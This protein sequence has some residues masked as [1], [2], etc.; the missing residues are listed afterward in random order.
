MHFDV[1]HL[2]NGD[3]LIDILV[4]Y[5]DLYMIFVFVANDVVIALSNCKY[6]QTYNYCLFVG[7]EG[8]IHTLP[9]PV[10]VFVY[11]ISA[12]FHCDDFSSLTVVNSTVYPFVVLL[13]HCSSL[14]LWLAP[15]NILYVPVPRQGDSSSVVVVG[16][17]T[18]YL[19]FINCLLLNL[20]N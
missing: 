12:L 7:C 8:C 17:Y 13:H 18:S 10:S 14:V 19:F 20:I 4:L 6:S 1:N 15:L 5:I 16:S 2:D 11:C 9:R 3:V